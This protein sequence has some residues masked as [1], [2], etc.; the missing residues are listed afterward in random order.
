MN[1]LIFECALI[2]LKKVFQGFGFLSCKSDGDTF[3]GFND[4]SINLRDSVNRVLIDSLFG[5]DYI[6]IFAEVHP[7]EP[8]LSAVD[9]IHVVNLQNFLELAVSQVNIEVGKNPLKLQAGDDIF[10]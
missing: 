3:D 2:A 4:S 7:F 5:E 1:S 10:S 9:S 8:L 6:N